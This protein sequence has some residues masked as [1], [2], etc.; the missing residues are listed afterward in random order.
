MVIVGT[1][2]LAGLFDVITGEPLTPASWN[3]ISFSL[4]ANKQ[5]SKF[6][7]STLTKFAPS[8]ERLSSSREA[9]VTFAFSS[10]SSFTNCRPIIPDPPVTSTFLF[11]KKDIIFLILLNL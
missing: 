10:S 6:L 8:I 9:I 3:T 1:K 11:L 2:K 7:K 4:H 5:L